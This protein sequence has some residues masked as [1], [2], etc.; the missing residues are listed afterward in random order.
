MADTST[1]RFIKAHVHELLDPL[2]N[3]RAAAVPQ[4]SFGPFKGG[5]EL[6]GLGGSHSHSCSWL[7]IT[8]H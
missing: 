7:Y 2:L 6:F 3:V 5:Q 4:V 8:V 1:N